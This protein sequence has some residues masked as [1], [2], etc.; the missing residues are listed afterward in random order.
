MT[1]EWDPAK[2]ASNRRKHKVGFPEAT[3]VFDDRLGTTFPDEAHST[4]EEERFV[5]LGMS[6]KGRLLVV[7]HAERGNALRISCDS[8]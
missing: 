3:T 5:T 2:A 6:A 8:R 7:I 4:P 1:F